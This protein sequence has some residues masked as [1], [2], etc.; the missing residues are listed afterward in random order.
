MARYRIIYE[1]VNINI[2]DNDKA[3]I[4][5]LLIWEANGY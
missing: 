4:F 3:G 2:I 5:Q 1:V